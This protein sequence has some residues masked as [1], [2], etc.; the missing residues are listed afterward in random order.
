MI[1]RSFAS[2]LSVTILVTVLVVMIA[3]L[4]W[5]WTRP[6]WQAVRRVTAVMNVIHEE[7][8]YPDRADYERL[9]TA[10]IE[11]MM[12]SLDAYSSYMPAEDFAHFE[13]IT[14]Q[15]YVGIGVRIER[16]NERV[17]IIN[18]FPEGPAAE[19]G[20]KPGDYFLA[21]DGEGVEEA[22]LVEVSQRLRGPVGESTQVTVR[23]P[24][25]DERLDFEITRRV[26]DLASV[27]HVSLDAEGIG[28][29]R[30]R[31]FGE[32]TAKE[33]REALEQLERDGMEGLV[34]DL[35]NNPGGLLST[36]KEV[37][38]EFFRRNELIVYTE[39]RGRVD[40]REYRSQSP[41]RL[42]DYPLAI[43]INGQSA[44]G[45]EIVAGAL[46]DTGKAWVVGQPSYG[47]GSV[48]SI[49]AFRD[50]AGLRQTTS[51]YFLPSGRS[52]NETGIVPDEV[53][54][55]SRDEEFRLTVQ[56]RHAGLLTPEAFEA[57]FEFAPDA[58]DPQRDAARRHV[59]EAL[60]LRRAK[61]A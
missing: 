26:V 48:Q 44:S 40:R 21:V 54:E 11:G 41:S 52:I 3:T 36:S 32:R 5:T 9:T 58:A 56:E 23:R 22:S 8:F 60:E 28:F 14:N 30:I 19:A 34:I 38:G 20:L 35:R 49:Y 53:V 4:V 12:Q 6:Y 7:Y 51:L 46:Q 24:Q 27:D 15:A 16:F 55:L 45:A 10:A 25:T 1:K 50:G 59:L 18:C 31:Q 43:L 17:T 13:Q 57:H 42:R 61:T 2:H 47:K 29:L 37:A 39:G 33:F